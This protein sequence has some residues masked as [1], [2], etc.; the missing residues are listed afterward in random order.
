[1][2]VLF[3]Q[4][5]PYIP[6]F[7]APALSQLLRSKE[8][9]R[10]LQAELPP[11]SSSFCPHFTNSFCEQMKRIRPKKKRSPCGR[12]KTFFRR[13]KNFGAHAGKFLCAQKNIFVRTKIYFCAHRN[14][15]A[16]ARKF[17]ALR[18]EAFFLPKGNL[19]SFEG[20]GTFLPKK[21]DFPAL[22]KFPPS[23]GRFLFL[24]KEKSV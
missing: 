24:R 19:F 14:F 23:A 9:A 2:G 20:K 4:S 13:A 3:G 12:K 10:T 17:F 16:C 15:S 18:K 5:P 22:E 11:T 8:R 21:K 1:M 7:G 6:D